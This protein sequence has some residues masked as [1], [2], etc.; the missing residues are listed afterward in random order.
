MEKYKN[1]SGCSGVVHYE[2]GLES[3]HV[4]FHDGNSQLYTYQRSGNKN[5]EEMKALAQKGEG[6]NSFIMENIKTL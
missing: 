2:I 3:I 4:Y 5:V 1:L 6:L